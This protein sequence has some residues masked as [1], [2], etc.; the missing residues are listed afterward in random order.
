MTCR[1][2]RRHLYAFGMTAEDSHLAARMYKAER[3]EEM[4]KLWLSRCKR[5]AQIGGIDGRDYNGSRRTIC[6]IHREIYRILMEDG[7]QDG[8]GV[9][10]LLREAY[11]SGKKMHNKLRAYRR[12]RDA[13]EKVDDDYGA[14]RLDG[15]E[16]DE[17]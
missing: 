12:L 7:Y 4:P 6:Q 14:H 2:M 16:I 13:C 3:Y 1:E 10:L 15:G 9:L 8:E 11:Q 17:R 5:L